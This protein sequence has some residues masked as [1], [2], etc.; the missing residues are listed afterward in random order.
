MDLGSSKS[1]FTLIAVVIFGVF[2]SLSYW[3]FQDELKGVL[4]SVLD[5]S[6]ASVTNIVLG[7]SIASDIN[8]FSYNTSSFSNSDGLVFSSNGTIYAGA[9]IDASIL[10][11]N[12]DYTLAF[13][14]TKLSGTIDH[15]GGHANLSDATEVYLDGV[16]KGQ[17]WSGGSMLYPDD[18]E[19]HRL[20]INFNS[21]NMAMSTPFTNKGIFIQPNRGYYDDYTKAFEVRIDDITLVER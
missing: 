3:M 20:V 15:L 18:T 6:K 4:A 16:Y 17:D 8:W 9:G 2:L 12:K 14:I 21:N 11:N 19:A 1:L 10:E 5:G 13:T 7:S